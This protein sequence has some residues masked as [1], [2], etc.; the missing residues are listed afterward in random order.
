MG[1][2]PVAAVLIVL[3]GGC[4]FRPFE[5]PSSSEIPAGPGLFTGKQ[6]EWV[7]VRPTA[8]P[9][10]P[11]AKPAPAADGPKPLLLAPAPAP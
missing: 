11:A 10:P 4:G 8:P 7:I 5:P 6:G 9:T 2:R 1:L 3:L